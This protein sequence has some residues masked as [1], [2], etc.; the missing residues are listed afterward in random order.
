MRSPTFNRK[1]TQNMISKYTIEYTTPFRKHAQPNH[2]LTDDPVACEEFIEEL[3]ER[4]FPIR[5]IKHEGLDLPKDEFDRIIKT[6][7]GMMAS[8]HI[9]ASLGI[10]PE[11]EKFRFG[12]AA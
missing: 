11:E 8:K 12:F 4:G 10:K 9:C 6:A 1:P 7:A 2:Y 5:A 3:L